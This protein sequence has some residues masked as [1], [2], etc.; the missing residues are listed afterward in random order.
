MAQ[1]HERVEPAPFDAAPVAAGETPA[2]ATGAPRWALPA[3][4]GLAVLVL[5]VLFWL[6]GRIAAPDSTGA[7]APPAESAAAPAPESAAEPA[8]APAESSPFA[9]AQA[10]RLRG[11]AQD[12]LAE[13]LDVRENLES[14]GAASWAAEAM[15]AIDDSAATGDNLYRERDFEAAIARYRQALERALTLEARLPTER[16][17]QLDAAA[18]A[19]EAGDLPAAERAVGLAEKIEAGF[20]RT[21]ALRA[22]VEALPAVIAGLETAAEAEASGDLAAARDALAEATAADPEHR[23]AAAALARVSEALTRQRFTRAMSEG[24]AALDAEAFDAARSAFRRADGLLPGRSEAAAGLQEVEAAESAATLRKL[25]EA[26]AA[27]S[28][29]EDWGEAVRRYEAALAL[30]ASVLFAQRGLAEAAPRAA[31]DTA[32]EKVID[33]PDRLADPAVAGDADK[34]LAR[35]RAALGT[36]AASAPRLAAQVEELARLLERANTPVPVT[37]RS[38]GETSVTLYRVARLGSFDERTLELRPGEYTAV[39]T[40]P[41]Y[42][43]VRETFRVAPEDPPATITVAC[44]EAI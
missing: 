2:A 27:A 24:Y 42:R 21:A 43:D 7:S 25:R 14:R 5:L 39:G 6:P 1:E 44:N 18:A 23:R 13:L 36:D 35:A 34:L 17:A 8:P 15:A 40:R 29:A 32:L 38:D 26:A 4:G 16:D 9:A 41:G 33:D 11:E 28:A 37:L 31:L 19:I 22:R 10:A 30:D 12:I 20:P 3:L